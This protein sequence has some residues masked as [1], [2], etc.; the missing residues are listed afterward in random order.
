MRELLFLLLFGMASCGDPCNCEFL[1][2]D[3]FNSS[4]VPNGCGCSVGN[5]YVPDMSA[6]SEA[7]TGNEVTGTKDLLTGHKVK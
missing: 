1:S 2:A 5:I 4:L 7:D 3:P 6:D